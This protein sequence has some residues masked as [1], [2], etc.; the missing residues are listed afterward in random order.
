LKAFRQKALAAALTL[1]AAV[2]S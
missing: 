1:G 2:F